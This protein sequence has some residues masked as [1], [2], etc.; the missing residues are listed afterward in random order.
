MA[1]T[2]T[3]NNFLKNEHKNRK[4]KII[5]YWHTHTKKGN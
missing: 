4:K 5:R 2:N 3:I 1:E